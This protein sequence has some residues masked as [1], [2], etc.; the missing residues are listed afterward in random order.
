MFVQ[1]DLA[2]DGVS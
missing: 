1:E 2:A